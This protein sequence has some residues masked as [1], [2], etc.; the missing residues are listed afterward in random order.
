M[1]ESRRDK[2]ETR[3][4]IEEVLKKIEEDLNKIPEL[5]SGMVS[6]WLRR[7]RESH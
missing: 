4:D 5:P 7:D 2:K 1:K 6:K 3:T